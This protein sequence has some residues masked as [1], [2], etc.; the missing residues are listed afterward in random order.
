MPLLVG[1]AYLAIPSDAIF[2][3]EY[4]APTILDKWAGKTGGYVPDY[5]IWLRG[6]PILIVEAKAPDVACE[7]G[8]REAS[9][10]ARHINQ[11]YP[12]GTNPCHFLLSS[13]GKKLLIGYWDSP[14]VL[15]VDVADLQPG[16]TALNEVQARCGIEPLAGHAIQ[17]LQRVRAAK[18]TYP[19]LLAGGSAILKAK[20][21]PNNFAADLS[22]ILRRY[23]SS[24]HQDNIREIVEKAYVNSA[25]V[26]E[27]DRILQALLKDR[28]SA[29]RAPMLQELE[30]R[31]RGE[32]HIDRAI[33]EFQRDR[34]P[35]GQLQ[36]IQGA[37]GSGKSLFMRRYRQVLQ[38]EGL[39]SLT[40]W[41]FVDFNTSQADLSHAEKWLC[42]AFIED[43]EINN[44]TIDLSSPD[45]LRGMFA[46]NLQRRKAYYEEINRVSPD[47]AA[48]QRAADLVMWREDPHET[49]RGIAN[50]VIGSR[51]EVLIVVMDNVDKLDLANQLAAFQ[52]SLWFMSQTRSF[53]ILQM[54]DETYERYKNRPPLDTF[55]TGITF[56]I[57]PP[58]FV[59]VVKRRLELSL[60]F[61]EN[62][63]RGTQH[64]EVETGIRVSYPRSEVANFLKLLYSELFDRKRNVS[65]L[66]EAMAGWDV[67]RALEMFV[68]MVTSGHFKESVITSSL[69]GKRSGGISEYLLLKIL[70]RTEYQF[71]SEHSGFVYNIFA[72]DPDWERPD[73]FLLIEI[74]YFL[75]I[76]RKKVGQ[77]GLE[78]YFTREYIGTSLQ[79]YGYTTGDV[80]KALN[81]LLKWKLIGADHMNFA[82]VKQDDSV[83][84]LASGYMHVRVLS[85]RIEYLY[86]VIPTTPIF[87]REVAEQFAGYVTD[88]RQRG[89]GGFQ[90]ANAVEGLYQ[91]LLRQRKTNATPFMNAG[92]TGSDYVLN[93][94][95]GSIEHFRNPRRGL[96]VDVD[97]LDT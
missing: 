50:Y 29:H 34:P 90:M 59:D 68:S 48:L 5:S 58:R 55:R 64:Y 84:V 10:Y 26:T 78:G 41:A 4:L 94:I 37:V 72:S 67:R 8:Y 23:F 87:E 33:F 3:K 2:T 56:H 85:G 54:R 11:E 63:A 65:R 6:F 39:S 53:V 86:G 17:C 35:A 49:A 27:Y 88:E 45:V 12:S 32:E 77:I 80:G 79:R 43:F 81:L 74:L 89:V 70:M 30:P 83:R 14:P 93:Q 51:R 1:S 40:R 28:I 24:S 13:N 96:P 31:K 19:Y 15:E 71:F 7:V 62:D 47:Q 18:A 20:L 46:R 44:P 36:I 76:N 60:E 97:P 42:T 75:A 82:E 95:V 66:M 52:L 38:P 16:T 22:P 73:N 61:L 9:L 21:P 92:A 25:E 91:Y 69:L 57:S